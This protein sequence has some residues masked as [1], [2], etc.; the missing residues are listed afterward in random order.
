[1]FLARGRPSMVLLLTLAMVEVQTISA[2]GL[3]GTKCSGAGLQQVWKL[4]STPVCMVWL[5]D[6]VE[7]ASHAPYTF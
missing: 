6:P 5:A 4:P 7:E 2:Q 1:M 3:S